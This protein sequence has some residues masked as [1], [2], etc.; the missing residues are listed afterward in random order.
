MP[1]ADNA[2][3]VAGRPTE[4]TV[5]GTV[6]FVLPAA[7]PP[8]TYELR[9]LAQNRQ[10]L[11]AISNRFI[12]EPG[13]P[14]LT[15][16]TT[17]VPPGGTLSAIWSDT[18]ASTSRVSLGLY[19]PG[20]TRLSYGADLTADGAAA[21][22]VLFTLPARIQAGTYELRLFDSSRR[23][24]LATSN[25]FTV[26]P[27]IPSLAVGSVQYRPGSV[28]SV[29]WSRIPAPTAADWIGLFAP[30]AEDSA[31]LLGP[32]PRNGTTNGSAT[33]PLPASLAPG[34][35]EVRLF[36]NAGASRLATSNAFIVTLN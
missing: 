12:V 34:I 36:A 27:G 7:L 15:I 32:L 18:A 30:G 33:V 1:G 28:V 13:T 10:T 14:S 29:A 21:G 24:L 16:S 25:R 2:D 20:S 22:S 9:L 31:P 19:V 5:F 3:P 4:G 26:E 8:G 35:Y 17:H 6:P 23:T 11:L